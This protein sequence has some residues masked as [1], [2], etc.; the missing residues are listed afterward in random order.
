MGG[1]T[2]PLVAQMKLS[3]EG[4]SDNVA[5]IICMGD[6]S[7]HSTTSHVCRLYDIRKH[8]EIGTLLQQEGITGFAWT[9]F[10]FNLSLSLSLSLSHSASGS[11]TWLTF[12]KD[13]LLLSASEDGTVCVWKCGES[14]QCLATLTGHKSVG[15]MTIMLLL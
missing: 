7:S 13:R 8:T 12:H 1:G 9:T 2:W 5:I 10:F 11:I 14:W 3:S 15:T 4:K 6:R